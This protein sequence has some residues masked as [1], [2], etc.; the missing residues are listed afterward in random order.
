[1][2]DFFA[3][4]YAYGDFGLLALRLAVAGIFI[5]HGKSKFAKWKPGATGDMLGLM[6]FLAIAETLGGIA[7]LFGFLTH[8]A[9][10]GLGIIMLGA[11]KMKMFKWKMPFTAHDK[12]GWEFDVLILAVCM[13]LFFFGPGALSLDRMWF[14]L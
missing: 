11:T 13:A 6:K 2:M 7:M 3:S 5:V 10:I 12:V 4:M 14:G 9:A 8:L 1:M